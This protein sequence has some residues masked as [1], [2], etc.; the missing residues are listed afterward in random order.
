M[1]P[2]PIQ[3]EFTGHQGYNNCIYS[4]WIKDAD[5]LMLCHLEFLWKHYRFWKWVHC[6]PVVCCPL[7]L[8]ECSVMVCLWLCLSLWHFSTLKSSSGGKRTWSPPLSLAP[9]PPARSCLQLSFSRGDSDRWSC[10]WALGCCQGDSLQ[11]SGV[12]VQTC[13]CLDG[14]SNL[15][16][17]W[18]FSREVS[19]SL[20]R[21][22]PSHTP[23]RKQTSV[24]HNK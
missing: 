11:I 22:I 10:C 5:T 19:P 24:W 3:A 4:P 8:N 23:C 17:P 12:P 18:E 1:H 9:P 2:V 15:G 21:L 7:P 13:H 6:S 14:L 20:H 16:S